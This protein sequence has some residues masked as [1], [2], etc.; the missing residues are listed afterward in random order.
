MTCPDGSVLA[1][2]AD[3]HCLGEGARLLVEPAEHSKARSNS[4]I[5]AAFRFPPITKRSISQS[6][7][8]YHNS[9][10]LLVTTDAHN[11]LQSKEIRKLPI[12]V[13]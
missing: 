3:A 12:R 10:L 8:P 9:L 6:S 4:P 13:Y 1:G 5:V 2:I 7:L 11:G